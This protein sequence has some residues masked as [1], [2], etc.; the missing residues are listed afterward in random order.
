TWIE[1]SEPFITSSFLRSS[2]SDPYAYAHWS[3]YAD[4]GLANHDGGADPGS[5]RFQSCDECQPEPD[6]GGHPLPSRKLQFH[7]AV[8]TTGH[9]PGYR[10]AGQ[11]KCRSFPAAPWN[12]LGRFRKCM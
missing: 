5:N 10:Y 2:S 8:P 3:W 9:H 1:S 6:G 11:E 12:G 7:H 4:H